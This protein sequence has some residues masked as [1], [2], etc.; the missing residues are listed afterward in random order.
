MVDIV[1]WLIPTIFSL[2]LLGLVYF[3]ARE[4][5]R[6]TRHDPEAPTTQM[7]SLTELTEGKS[8]LFLLSK[9]DH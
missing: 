7:S 3:I 9:H 6:Q 4:V 2:G 5:M 8:C 1:T